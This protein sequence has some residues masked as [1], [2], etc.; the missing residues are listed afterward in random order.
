MK[1][2]ILSIALCLSMLSAVTACGQA[3]VEKESSQHEQASNEVSASKEESVS[4]EVK[5]EPVTITMEIYD[6]GKYQGFINVDKGDTVMDNKMVNL[7]KEAALE[8]LNINIE[9]VAIQTSGAEDKIQALMAAETEPDIFFTY[10]SD[11]FLKWAADGALADLTDYVN[12][13]E[14]GKALSEFL[15]EDALNC[16]QL[17]GRQYAIN[18]R[19]NNV[20]QLSSFIRKDLVEAV[21]MELLEVNDHYAMTPSMLKEALTKIKVEGY[22]DFPYGLLNAWQCIS[23]ITGAFVDDD[24]FDSKEQLIQNAEDTF[25]LLDGTKESYRFLNECYNEGLI[26]PDFALHAVTNLQEMVTNGDCAFWTLAAYQWL[27]T[28][29]A[30]HQFHNENPDGEWVAVEIVQEDLSPARYYK[31]NPGTAWGMVSSNCENVE[32]AVRLISWLNTDETAHLLTNHGV[33]GET[34]TVDADGDY[35]LTDTSYFSGAQDM[36]MWLNNCSCTRNEED[37]LRSFRKA[38]TENDPKNITAYEDA[39]RIATS[40]GKEFRIFPSA[41]IEAQSEWAADLAENK[42]N[43]IIQSITTSTDKFDEVYDR[44]FEIYMEEGGKQIAEERLA[45]L[46]K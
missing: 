20:S 16:G 41:V 13:T 43:L 6:R 35:V 40:E 4:A 29:S 10:N 8:E 27:S 14:Y 45:T 9:Y 24:A 26:H 30:V 38:N 3:E 37:F 36:N 21:G 31:A 18:G 5:E 1:K 28:G 23:P 7:M 22:V 17:K 11:R 12:N 39:F 34:Y 46:Q 33:E 15:G 25:F 42:D 44:Y 2:R 19:N 32:A